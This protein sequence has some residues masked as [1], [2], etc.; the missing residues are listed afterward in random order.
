MNKTIFLK[1]S[2]ENS[3]PNEQTVKPKA[4]KNIENTTE[5]FTFLI[6]AF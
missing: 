2:N 1:Y 4:K 3:E 5:K 6:I